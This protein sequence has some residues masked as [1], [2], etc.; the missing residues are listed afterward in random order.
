[1]PIPP[2]IARSGRKTYLQGNFTPKNPQKFL[3][4]MNGSRTAT[5]RSSWELKL[6]IAM[7]SS[8]T[9]LRWGSEIIV[10]RYVSP[11]DHKEHHYYIDFYFEC[12]DAVTGAIKRFWAECKPYAETIPPPIPKRKTPKAMENYQ[13]KAM[14]YAQNMAKWDAAKKQAER[15]PNT[16]FIVI[17]ERNMKTLR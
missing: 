12:K 7:D 10:C 3:G 16:T 6:M 2:K 5:Y 13:I 15:H 8:K 9:F 17:T 14:T 4:G 11:I 1:M